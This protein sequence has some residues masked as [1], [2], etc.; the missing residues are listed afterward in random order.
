M[1]T[2]TATKSAEQFVTALR[3]NTDAFLTDK[4]S[5]ADF[6]AEQ[7]RLWRAI[8]ANKT[9]HAAVLAALRA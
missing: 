1:K 3:A 4:V 8:E 2:R 6:G 7:S 5:H 9:V